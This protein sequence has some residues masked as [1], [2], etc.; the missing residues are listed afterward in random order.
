VHV[1]AQLPAAH[2]K[3]EHERM[4]LQPS[5]QPITLLSTVP[6]EHTIAAVPNFKERAQP[7][8]SYMF[9]IVNAALLVMLVGTALAEV[10]LT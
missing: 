5:R 9:Y 8:D 10:Y 4:Q 2:H 3:H 1:K 6:A 7:V